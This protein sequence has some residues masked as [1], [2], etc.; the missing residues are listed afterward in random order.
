VEKR[1]EVP[2]YIDRPTIEYVERPPAA[3]H[4]CQPVS[5]CCCP[6][7]AAHPSAY[8]YE[9]YDGSTPAFGYDHGYG[10]GYGGGSYGGG[11]YYGSGGYEALYAH[12]A[13][14]YGYGGCRY[15][16]YSDL[17]D[18]FGDYSAPAFSSYARLGRRRRLAPRRHQGWEGGGSTYR[19]S[20]ARYGALPWYA[21][22]SWQRGRSRRR[23]AWRTAMQ[24]R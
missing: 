11:G 8:E 20:L 19:H 2:T 3:C 14:P 15:D 1:V 7:H 10:Y 24:G 9:K 18:T 22:T 16:A 13:P 4:C 21:G 6:G 12:T 23:A 5:H 17:G